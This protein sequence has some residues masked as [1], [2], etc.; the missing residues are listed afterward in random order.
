MLLWPVQLMQPK[1]TSPHVECL[2]RVRSLARSIARTAP[3][4]P[5]SLNLSLP[6]MFGCAV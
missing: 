2:A 1:N 4:K 5:V 3:P 6:R